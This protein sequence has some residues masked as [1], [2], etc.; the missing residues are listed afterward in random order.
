MQYVWGIFAAVFVGALYLGGVAINSFTTKL[1]EN[2]EALGMER[3]IKMQLKE[4]NTGLSEDLKTVLFEIQ[5]SQKMMRDLANVDDKT[6]VGPAGT[7]FL[8]GVRSAGP[9]DPLPTRKPSGK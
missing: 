8:D 4:E 5:E 6:E 3:V 9:R 7:V 2:S 1:A